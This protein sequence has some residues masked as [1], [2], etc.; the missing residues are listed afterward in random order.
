[1]LALSDGAEKI[2]GDDRADMVGTRRH[3][4]YC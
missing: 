3:S 2:R 1:V 4:V